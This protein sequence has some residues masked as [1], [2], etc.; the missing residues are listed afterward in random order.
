MCTYWSKCLIVIYLHLA[1]KAILK[2]PEESTAKFIIRLVYVNF[3]QV[4]LNNIKMVSIKL[5]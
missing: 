3:A 4:Y 2:Y 1:N 5:N